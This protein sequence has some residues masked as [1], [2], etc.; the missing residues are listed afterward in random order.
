MTGLGPV[1]FAQGSDHPKICFLSKYGIFLTN[2]VWGYDS[3][4]QVFGA[5]GAK[6]D[7]HRLFSHKGESS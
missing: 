2:L 4:N 3:E 5:N 6:I 7:F 1:L